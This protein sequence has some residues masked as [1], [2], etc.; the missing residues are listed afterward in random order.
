MTSFNRF[1][2]SL[3]NGLTIYLLNSNKIKERWR[4]LSMQLMRGRKYGWIENIFQVTRGEFIARNFLL[5]ILDGTVLFDGHDGQIVSILKDSPLHI[6]IHL[7]RT[8]GAH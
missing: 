4:I 5:V 6:I 3:E 8:K 1:A 2:H 7:P